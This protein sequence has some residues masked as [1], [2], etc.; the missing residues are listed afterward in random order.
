MLNMIDEAQFLSSFNIANF[1]KGPKIW[2]NLI[3]T[4][5]TPYN[6]FTENAKLQKNVRFVFGRLNREYK[7]WIVNVP[8]LVF[9]QGHDFT[10]F[11]PQTCIF[12]NIKPVI[13]LKRD[14]LREYKEPS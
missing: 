7:R 2:D 5:A 14:P 12:G 9:V 4:S 6:W 3:V 10:D 13:P 8:R 11:P 1:K